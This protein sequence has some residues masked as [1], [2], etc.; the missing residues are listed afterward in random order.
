[1]ESLLQIAMAL[2]RCWRMWSF[3]VKT[4]TLLI[5]CLC[6]GLAG[7]SSYA[8]SRAGI[9]PIDAVRNKFAAFNQH[10]VGAIEEIYSETATL[11]SPDYRNLVGNKPIAE[12]YRKIFDS[13]PDAKDN[14]ELL[15]FA[16]KRV[17][18]QFVLSGHWN[19]MQDK[20]VSVRIMAVYTVKDGRIVDD[21]TYYDRKP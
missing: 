1:M 2:S 7:G 12:T 11:N 8:A 17:Y 4:T 9:R 19:G 14:V 16:G 18:A 6:W 10:D 13:I 3:N 5:A 15:E 20:P 21:S